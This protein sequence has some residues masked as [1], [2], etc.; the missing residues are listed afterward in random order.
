[1]A[2]PLEKTPGAAPAEPT[3]AELAEI[4][5]DLDFYLEMDEATSL[6]AED[7]KVAEAPYIGDEEDANGRPN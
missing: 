5:A 3:E 1:M 2:E 7:E 4:L 6:P